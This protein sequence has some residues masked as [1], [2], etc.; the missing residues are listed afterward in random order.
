MQICGSEAEPF[1]SEDI[2]R[3]SKY[4]IHP[5]DND[6]DGKHKL[7]NIRVYAVGDV[8]AQK[9]ADYSR[10]DEYEK[11]FNVHHSFVGVHHGRNGAEKQ[12]YGNYRTEI[13]PCCFFIRGGIGFVEHPKK[14]Y[15]ASCP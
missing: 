14:D 6:E 5:C 13:I 8:G 7:Q 9:S 1:A 10:G 11:I 4:H 15:A 3:I 12:D 2:F